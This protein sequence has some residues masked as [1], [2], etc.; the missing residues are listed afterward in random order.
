MGCGMDP[1]KV[2]RGGHMKKLSLSILVLV[3][4]GLMVGTASAQLTRLVFTI[5]VPFPFMVGT[6]TLP[7][8]HYY[9]SG[10][11]NHDLIWIKSEDGKSVGLTLAIPAV[12]ARP[13]ESSALVFN[14][15]GNDYFLAKVLE[16]GDS[17]AAQMAKSKREREIAQSAAAPSTSRILYAKGGTR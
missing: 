1:R 15:Y 6:T 9:V 13:A 11:P 16:A 4:A 12:S 17:T 3:L 2:L 14:R 7:A 10:S 8:G 5:D